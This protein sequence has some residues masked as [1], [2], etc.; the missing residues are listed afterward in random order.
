MRTLILLLIAC[1]TTLASAAEGASLDAF[2]RTSLTITTASAR[3]HKF[4]IWVARTPEQQERGL[5]FV[6][7][8]PADSGMVFIEEPQRVMTM[9]MKNTLIPLD[10]LF[11][12]EDG[13]VLY[14]RQRATPHSLEIIKFDKP[15]RAVLELRG[16]ETK[17][18][19]IRTGDYVQGEFFA[20]ISKDGR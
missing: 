20:P 5:M 13:R 19:G 3:Q 1:V 15:V 10:M 12:G 7:D 16:G 8:L 4:D 2:P 6:T 17:A 18:R 14:I 9:W 11:I